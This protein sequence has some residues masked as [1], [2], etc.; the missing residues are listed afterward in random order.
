MKCQKSSTA[1]IDNL[2]YFNLQ[3]LDNNTIF[4]SGQ[5]KEGNPN[6]FMYF[7][8]DCPHCRKLTQSILEHSDSLKNANIFFLTY[9]SIE[10]LKK[11]NDEFH[12]GNYKNIIIGKD[13]EYSFAKIFNPQEVPYIAI[14]NNN[15]KLVKVYNGII[16]NKMIYQALNKKI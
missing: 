7:R 11:Y 12:L 3:L 2:P 6:I 16:S 14:Y 10:E 5:I 8:T 4:N 1:N 9:D 13:Y 15:K